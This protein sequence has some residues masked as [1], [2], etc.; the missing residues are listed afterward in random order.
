MADLAINWTTLPIYGRTLSVATRNVPTEADPNRVIVEVSLLRGG[1][2][3]YTAE[4]A[5]PKA[6]GALERML[7]ASIA[8]D[9]DVRWVGE[10]AYRWDGSCWQDLRPDL[11][12][13]G[14]ALSNV[15]GVRFESH[16]AKGGWLKTCHTAGLGLRGE[17]AESVQMSAFG[18]CLG[19]PLRDGVL[20]YAGKGRWEL[21]PHDRAN[22]NT[23]TLAATSDEVLPRIRKPKKGGLL[24][25]YLDSALNADQ[26]EFLSQWLGLHLIKHALT[27]SAGQKFL[28]LKGPGGDG[29]SQIM[30]LIAGLVG[31]SQVAHIGLDG[32]FDRTYHVLENKLAMLSPENSKDVPWDV[33][34]VNRIT[35]GEALLARPVYELPRTVFP[36]C[37]ITQACNEIPLFREHSRALE[38]RMLVFAMEGRFDG[39]KDEVR[40]IGKAIIA[41]EFAD[42]VGWALLGAQQIYDNDGALDIPASISAAGRDVARADIAANSLMAD[43]EWGA[44][45]ISTRELYSYYCGL[46]AESGK[47]PMSKPKLIDEL[48]RLAKQ[49]G[50]RCG[51]GINTPFTPEKLPRRTGYD[52]AL[53]VDNT[54]KKR[55]A[56][57]VSLVRDHK[58]GLPV[59]VGEREELLFGC[60][61][62][63]DVLDDLHVGLDWDGVDARQRKP[64]QARSAQ[65]DMLPTE[66]ARAQLHEIAKATGLD[67]DQL[68]A[69]LKAANG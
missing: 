68:E 18:R 37:L 23:A 44:Y 48:I 38:R 59:R 55:A 50:I 3:A 27:G 52:K 34:A 10:L 19:V 7:A 22:G 5:N 15:L 60:R 12:R 62:K 51:D 63:S 9:P 8:A 67:R 56:G 45:A 21:L 53:E 58:T 13:W 64:G 28:L 4:Q 30:E 35:C 43:L 41:G 36:A 33:R 17:S 26:R 25:R 16:I 61:I 66:T 65:V 29:K 57:P 14:G 32:L 46:C 6:A 1:E 11:E 24:A 20:R 54:W 31:Q 47:Q 2:P 42:L 69:L 40:D 49:D 39:T